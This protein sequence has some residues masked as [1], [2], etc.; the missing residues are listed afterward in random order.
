MKQIHFDQPVRISFGKIGKTRLVH[1]VWEAS[2]CLANDKWPDRSGPMF[3]MAAGALRGTAQ[4]QVTAQE[5]RQAFVDA[6][7]EARILVVSGR[8]K[9]THG[10]QATSSRSSSSIS[11]KSGSS[12]IGGALVSFGTSPGPE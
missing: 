9:R 5:A 3:E 4:G 1:T 6:A 10:D 8:P 7:L 2:K 11:S 12:S